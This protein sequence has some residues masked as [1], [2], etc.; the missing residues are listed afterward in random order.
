MDK[1]TKPSFCGLPTAAELRANLDKSASSDARAQITAIFDEKTF[2]E[3]GAYTKRGFSDFLNTEKSCEFEGVI[4][5]YGAIDGKLAFAFVEDASR[6]GGAMDERHAKKIVELYRLALSNGA[7]VIGI[8]NSNGADIFQGTSALAAYGKVMS[9]VSKASGVIPQIA[10]VAGKCIGTAAAVASMFDIVV[11]EESALL[12]VS[13]PA[14]TGAQDAQDA[15]AAYTG[16]LDQCAGFIRTIV[17]F[18]PANSSVGIQCSDICSD[19]LNRMLG[20]LDFAGEALSTISVIA[21]NGVFIELS[22]SY[23]PA[24]VTA[25]TT[26]AGVK[27]GVVATSFAKNEGRIT[28]DAARK[29]AKFVNLCDSF[30]IPV[31]TIVDS[32]GLAIDKE[33]ETRFAPELAKL[34]TAY[35]SSTCPKITVIAGHAIGAA[36][37]LLGSKALGADLVYATDSSEIGALATESGVAFAWDKYITEET[38][39][40]SLIEDWRASV[41]SPVN[42]ASSGEIDDIISVNEM[43]ARICSALLMLA[44]KGD[45]SLT[46]RR[47]I[48]PL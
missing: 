16:S 35:A 8:F 2:V 20:N 45:A 46:A 24:S 26:I 48:L 19:N 39:R 18:L 21:D 4:T 7:P 32:Y 9:V 25:F 37:V 31:I 15:I 41:S 43:R 44:A 38:T 22:G 34:A 29:I 12:Y 17:G 30:S 10:F 36:F 13:S 47:K 1:Y 40:D 27:C 23:A 28:A 3:T 11:K 33:N 6:M 42:A 5:G 14:L